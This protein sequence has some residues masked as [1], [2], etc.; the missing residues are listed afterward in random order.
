M[1]IG[2]YVLITLF[3]MISNND[4]YVINYKNSIEKISL[5][6][7]VNYKYDS[8]EEYIV[9]NGIGEKKNSVGQYSLNLL[10]TELSKCDSAESDINHALEKYKKIHNGKKPQAHKMAKIGYMLDEIRDKHKH[11]KQC[12]RYIKVMQDAITYNYTIEKLKLELTKAKHTEYK[13]RTEY[14]QMA[15]DLLD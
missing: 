13:G 12:Q 14:Y 2:L 11:I 10:N 8:E 4:D 15:L 9:I 5:K 6:E 1:R 7:E 3:S